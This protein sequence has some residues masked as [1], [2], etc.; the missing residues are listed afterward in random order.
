MALSHLIYRS[1]M[2][3]VIFKATVNTLDSEYQSMAEQLRKTAL[4]EF[5]CLNFISLSEGKE[6]ITLSYWESEIHIQQWKKHLLHQT[7]QE[8][9]RLLYYERYTVEV[10]EISRSYSFPCHDK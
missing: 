2:F 4:S 6:E 7:A 3:V 9:G 5:G 8:K 10:A 1:I